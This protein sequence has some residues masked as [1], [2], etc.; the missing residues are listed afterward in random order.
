LDAR[1]IYTCGATAES[2]NK[3]IIAHSPVGCEVVFAE[4]EVPRQ[5]GGREAQF[6]NRR[7][8]IEI[9]ACWKCS[10]ML[11]RQQIS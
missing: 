2:V 11:Q 9:V 1:R 8:P 4:A 7:L 5:R 3:L 6:L 10:A